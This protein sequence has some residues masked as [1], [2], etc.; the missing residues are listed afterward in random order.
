VIAGVWGDV[1]KN[2]LT[3]IGE[4]PL[5]LHPSYWDFGHYLLFQRPIGKITALLV[6][7]IFV[8]FLFGVGMA[9]I[10]S[11]FKDT[12]KTKYAHSRGILFGG[13]IWFVIRSAITMSQISELTPDLYAVFW[14]W[15]TAAAYGFTVSY[16]VER[17]EK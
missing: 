8:E 11:Y 12:I 5:G 1:V 13:A 7:S 2:I 3:Y 17:L 16:F 9:V 10:Y 4:I 6:P 14:N 15:M